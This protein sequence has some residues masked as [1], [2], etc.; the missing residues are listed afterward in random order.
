MSDMSNSLYH[1][2]KEA[3]VDRVEAKDFVKLDTN[4]QILHRLQELYEKD[5]KIV[6]LYGEPGVGKTM[7]LH[8]FTSD[9]DNKNLHFFKQPP[10]D[11][12]ALNKKLTQALFGRNGYDILETLER[13]HSIEL[14]TIIIDEAQL[15]SQEQ[16]ELIRLLSDT[17][18][19]RFILSFHQLKSGE[20][21]TEAHFETRI[22]QKLHLPLPTSK[23]LSV[24]IQKRLF[25]YGAL[26]LA[27]L[28]SKK[29]TIT[30]Y[31]FTNGNLRKTHHFLYT[32]FDIMHYF[33]EHHPTLI[34]PKEIERK[35][36]EMAA[37][38]LGYINA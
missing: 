6:V 11:V 1:L 4:I 36:L 13:E 30:I 33:E 24:Y 35:F 25:H 28:F 31:N 14:Q 29:H 17:K 15:L 7:L 34:K 37:I 12:I 18:K 20:L 27:N 10:Q 2:A 23:E 22:A 8:K 21:I 19:V 38:K 26:E 32:L 5:F 9:L 3:F 16:L